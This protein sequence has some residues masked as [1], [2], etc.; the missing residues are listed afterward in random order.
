MAPCFIRESTQEPRRFRRSTRESLGINLKDSVV[1]FD[2]AHNLVDAVTAIH[3]SLVTGQQVRPVASVFRTLPRSFAQHIPTVRVDRVARFH[4]AGGG[5]P[6]VGFESQ[7]CY[8]T[9]R[10]R[11]YDDGSTFPD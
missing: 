2:E 8:G 10:C 11:L 6:K 7:A 4:A 5:S 3:S 9:R 1:I